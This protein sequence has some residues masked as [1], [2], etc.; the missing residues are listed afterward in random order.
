MTL[1]RADYCCMLCQRKSATRM[2]GHHCPGCR[3]WIRTYAVLLKSYGPRGPTPPDHLERLA[4]Y[5][6]RAE[7][8][9]DLFVNL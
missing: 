2:V 3:Q 4:R 6:A 5:K 7:K 9:L 1:S 8:G